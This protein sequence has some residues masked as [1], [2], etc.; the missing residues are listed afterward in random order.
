MKRAKETSTEP[1]KDILTPKQLQALPLWVK[2]FTSVAVASANNANQI[3]F[4][5][6]E[7]GG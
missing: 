6:D 2:G 5:N 7:K 4:T 1:L 3:T